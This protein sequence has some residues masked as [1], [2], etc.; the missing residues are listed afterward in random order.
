MDVVCLNWQADG[1]RSCRSFP[2]M[3][4]PVIP[5]SNLKPQCHAGWTPALITK[6][7]YFNNQACFTDIA[8]F[9]QLVPGLSLCSEYHHLDVTF[10][11]FV[12]GE[13][14]LLNMY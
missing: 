2:T 6:L 13:K 1:Q 7:L 14:N 5:A 12:L 9:L 10:L 11:A 4:L 3:I 8:Y